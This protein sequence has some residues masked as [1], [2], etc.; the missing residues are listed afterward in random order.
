MT[1]I[2]VAGETLVDLLPGA[3]ETLRDVDGFTHRPGG[4]PANVAVGLSR[5]GAP[6]AFWTRLGDDPFGDFLRETLDEEGVPD[7]L[8]R[9]VGGNT[10]LAVVSPPGVDGRRFRFY[11][12]RDVTFGF[13]PDAVPTDALASASWVH[14][15]GVAL[16]HPRGRTAMRE[17]AAVADERG[18]TV[19]FDVNYRPDLVPEGD[20]DAVVEAIRDILGDTDVAFASDEDVAATGISSREGEDL[21][22]DLLDFGP[23]T[24]VV[25]LGSEGAVAA[26]MDAAPWGET[27]ARHGGFR[28]EAVDATGAGDAFTSGLIR[29][30]AARTDGTTPSTAAETDLADALAFANATAALSVRDRGGMT[31]LPDREAVEAFL[32]ERA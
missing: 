19:S 2:L 8:S 26:S 7:A 30:L 3:G 27:T 10:T 29:R 11:G 13:D 6:P 28:V 17:V 32:A 16:T 14:V 15:G 20:R 12:S 21:A 18:C 5:L 4:A 1:D 31:A 22:R 24:A 9:R 25:T 23:H